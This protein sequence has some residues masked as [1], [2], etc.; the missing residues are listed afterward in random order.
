MAPKVYK[1]PA[2]NLIQNFMDNFMVK[3][4]RFGITGP[5]E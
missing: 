1:E 4:G 3:K 2:E 5:G